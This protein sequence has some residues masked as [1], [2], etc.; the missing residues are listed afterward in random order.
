MACSNATVKQ[1]YLR[2]ARLS[3]GY[4]NRY[5]AST[6]VPFSAETLGRH[7]RGDTAI[8]PREAVLYA[9]QYGRPDILYQHCA[10]CPVGMKLGIKVSERDL[11]W[12]ALRINQRLR[13]AKQI[14]EELED[15]AEDGV[16][17]A[18]ERPR[19]QEVLDYLR[20]LS[21]IAT[22][23]LVWYFQNAKG[24]DLTSEPLVK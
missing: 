12:S 1:D 13:K 16:V 17:D 18:T 4:V 22:D 21:A 11:P 2:K 5:D 8:G 14:A 24:P 10:T 7:E 6:A 19:F 20:D 3:A 23:M 15:I 9:E